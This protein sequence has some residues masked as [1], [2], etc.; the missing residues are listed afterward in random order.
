M[1]L[2][3][4]PPSRSWEYQLLVLILETIFSQTG[5]ALIGIVFCPFTHRCHI[6]LALTSH[7]GLRLILV[8]SS[9]SVV[10]GR[11][12]LLGDITLAGTIPDFEQ[13]RG[14]EDEPYLTG[15]GLCNTELNLN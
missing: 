6:H 7:N 8:R 15:I 4:L 9:R 10:I 3:M 2:R 13:P 12:D 11:A 5:P 14:I 1:I